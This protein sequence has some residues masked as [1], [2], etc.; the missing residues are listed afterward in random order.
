[1]QF[2]PMKPYLLNNEKPRTTSPDALENND[3]N[4]ENHGLRGSKLEEKEEG[5][6]YFD[7]VENSST[8]SLDSGDDSDDLDG[9]EVEQEDEAEVTKGN[10]VRAIKE[11]LSSFAK[12]ALADPEAVEK[13]FVFRRLDRQEIFQI[14]LKEILFECM[15]LVRR[16]KE[17]SD[18][19]FAAMQNYLSA[20]QQV[21]RL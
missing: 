11:K 15:R 3:W 16:R 13:S 2:V 14:R 20:L 8:K 12:Q 19:A 7:F 21:S 18:G 5:K 4:E 9:F 17:V 10:I 1:M 6:K